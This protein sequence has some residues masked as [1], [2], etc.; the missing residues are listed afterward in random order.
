MKRIVVLVLSLIMLSATAVR[1]KSLRVIVSYPY[2]ASI[3]EQIGRDRLK[4]DYLARG[5]YDP[6][7]IVPKPSFIA[8]VRRADLLVINGAQLE[9]GWVPPLIK[10]ANNPAVN[11]GTEGFLELSRHVDLIDVPTSVSRSQ[12]D[13]HPDGNPHFYLDPHNIPPVARAIADRLAK[14]DHRN[15]SYFRGNCNDF[16][17]KFNAKTKEWDSQLQKC[18]GMEVIEYHKNFDYLLHR[19][20]MRL[21]GTVEPLPGIPPTSKHVNKLESVISASKVKFIIHD[22]Y[23]PDD[24]SRHLSQKHG[25]KLVVLPHDVGAVPEAGDIFKLYDE[26]VRRLSK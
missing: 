26:I 15:A 1:A 23:H 5:D 17:A 12:G 14:L 18:R 10:Q 8:K 6:H 24:A 22:V 11:P 16:I 20:N 3:V 9:I 21:V 7:T 2:M 19:C 25:I 13:V 4:V